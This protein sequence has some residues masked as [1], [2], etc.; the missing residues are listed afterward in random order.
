MEDSTTNPLVPGN[1]RP[2]TADAFATGNRP[3]D[4]GI[5]EAR[6][7][8][9]VHLDAAIQM[10]TDDAHMSDDQATYA[11]KTWITRYWADRET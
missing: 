5:Q 4:E 10:L 8:L 3:L 11:V 1:N 7:T 2:P 9:G 6:I